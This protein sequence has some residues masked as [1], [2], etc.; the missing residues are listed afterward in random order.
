MGY[1]M[2]GDYYRG[3]G[4]YAAG[5]VFSFL[6]KAAKTVLGLTPVG[7]IAQ[8]ALP[9]VFNTPTSFA[10]PGGQIPTTPGPPVPGVGG[11]ISRILPGG[12]SGYQSP[13]GYHWSK[14]AEKW[15]KNRHMNVT[16]VRALR[17]GARRVR[18]FLKLAGRLGALPVSRGGGKKLFKRKTKR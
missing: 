18:G 10:A 13:A 3:D 6:G 12:S 9:T 11:A 1:Y 17:R 14:T 16:N 15:V 4:N 5:G 7:K 2:A 8:A